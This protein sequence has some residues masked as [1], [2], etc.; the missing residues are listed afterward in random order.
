MENPAPEDLG[1]F[2]NRVVTGCAGFN[3]ND[4]FSAVPYRPNG[5]FPRVLARID[6]RQANANRV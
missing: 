6:A 3:L 1:E 2:L 4:N 5:L